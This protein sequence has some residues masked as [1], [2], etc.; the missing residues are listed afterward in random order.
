[1]IH[2]IIVKHRLIP[3]PNI[4]LDFNVKIDMTRLLH[5]SASIDI[6]HSIIYI[7]VT[8]KIK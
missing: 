6:Y 3:G 8:S 1:M 5:L 2:A 4:L 7:E